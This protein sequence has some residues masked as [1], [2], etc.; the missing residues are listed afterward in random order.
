MRTAR[1]FGRLALIVLM[2]AL[3]LSACD[4]S[5]SHAD[6]SPKRDCQCAAHSRRRRRLSLRPVRDTFHAFHPPR[7][8]LRHQPAA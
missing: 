5:Q 1:P 2:L 6:A 8:W 4:L 7:G 3:V